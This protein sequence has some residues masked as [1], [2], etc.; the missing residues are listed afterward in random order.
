MSDLSTFKQCEIAGRDVLRG[1]YVRIEP[2]NWELHGPELARSIAQADHQHLWTYLPI[3]PLTNQADL[4]ATM[5]FVGDL[6]QWQTMAICDVPSG[7]A[8]GTASYMRFRPEHGSVEVGCV[9]FGEALQKTR[10]A[11]EAMYLMA[12]H[13]FE[14]HG[15]RRYEWKCDNRNGASKRAAL[16]FGFSYE[17][18]FRQDMVMKGENRDTAWFSMTDK[19]W[20]DQKRVFD[21]WLSP[22]N[23][24]AQGL[25][26]K[27]LSKIRNEI[28]S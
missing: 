24:D 3:G 11:T 16:R 19:D 5:K 13:V 26:N 2:I 7:Q 15:Y 17:G 10:A 21:T 12:R 18:L 8:L 22:D 4:Q 25:Q 28:L 23:F 20:P 1:Q 14:T 9:I 27:S 6:K